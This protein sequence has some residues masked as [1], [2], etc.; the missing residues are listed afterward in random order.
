MNYLKYNYSNLEMKLYIAF[1]NI[2]EPGDRKYF[3]YLN[4]SYLTFESLD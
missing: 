4:L 3:F 1:L 2:N